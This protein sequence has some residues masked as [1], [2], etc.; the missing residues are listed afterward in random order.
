MQNYIKNMQNLH[1]RIKTIETL[2]ERSDM[3]KSDKNPH[4]RRLA[5]H[6]T[7]P[8]TDSF[9]FYFFQTDATTLKERK[10]FYGFSFTFVSHCMFFRFV[11]K[12]VRIMKNTHVI[13]LLLI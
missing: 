7:A 1:E 4:I 8:Y 12:F 11:W 9:S 10:R 2:A 3:M 6:L 5:S 13:I